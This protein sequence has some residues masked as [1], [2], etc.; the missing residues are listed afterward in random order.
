[1]IDTIA[2]TAI[3]EALQRRQLAIFV[4]ADL[5]QEVTGLPARTDLARELARRR[6]LDETLALAEVAQRVSQAG[7]RFE[8]TDFLRRALDI[9]GKPPQPLHQRLVE[10]VTTH[11]VETIITTAYDSLLAFAFEKAGA[12]RN[13]VVRDSDLSFANADWPTLIWLYGKVEQPDSLVVTDRDHSLLLRDRDKEAVVSEVRRTFQRNTVLLLG[14]DLADPDFRFLFD[15]GTESPFARTAYAVWPGLPDVD[16][17]M[18]RDRGIVI[19]DTDPLG[20]LGQFAAPVR[21][22]SGSQPAAATPPAAAAVKAGGDMN[23]TRGFQALRACLDAADAQRLSEL[24]TLESRF[25]ENQRVERIF[26]SSENTRNERAQI[27]FALNELALQ[28]CGVSFNELC[29]GVHAKPV[30]AV[31]PEPR[32]TLP[33]PSPRPE[34]GWVIFKLQLAHQAGLEFEAR[35]LAT[36][37]GEP[38]AAGRLPFDATDLIAVLKVLEH[39]GYDPAD[40][41]PV[42]TEALQRLGLVRDG[43]LAHDHLKHLG[44]GL[45]DAL[46]PGDVGVAFR[47]AFNQARQARQTIFLQLRFDSNAVDLARYPWELLHDGQRHLVSAGAVELT[48]YITYGEAAPAL[49]VEPP[50]RLLFVESRP[51]DLTTLPPESERLAVWNALQALT[52]KGKLVLDRLESPTYDALLDRMAGV[53]YHLIHFDGHGLFARRCPRCRSMNYPHLITCYSCQ[54]PLNDVSPQGYLAFED[55]AGK[56]DFVSTEDMENLL[57]NSQVRLLFL[58]ACQTSVVRGESLFGGL[59]PGLIRAGVP[60]VVAMQFSVPVSATINFA[61]SC[62]TAL[63]RG[64]TVPRAVAQGRRRLFRGNT[65]YVPTLYLRSQDDEGHIFSA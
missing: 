59:G 57:L 29:Q 12:G 58:S 2:A 38:N 42:Q 64:E 63:A 31:K 8:F 11:R 4:G 55:R 44:Q 41:T 7:S 19:L 34:Q 5:P 39:N 61:E 60:A 53:D 17:R 16:V 54:S 47:L 27:I 32:P 18:W 13:G 33:T 28:H 43:R 3:A 52:G 37:M 6:G 20:L 65:W 23:Y 45:Y 50:A 40:F 15:Q 9:T 10:L 62:Y 14:H 30:A 48:R 25:Q 35:A 46:F 56:A 24:S 26:G 51:Q 49:P 36:P 21:T 22:S 1:M